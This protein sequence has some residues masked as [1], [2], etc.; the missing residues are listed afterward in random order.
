[1]NTMT[2]KELAEKL[3]NPYKFSVGELA[4]IARAFSV[5]PAD[6]IGVMA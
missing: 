5:Q 6:L 3:A 1:M 2:A 4:A